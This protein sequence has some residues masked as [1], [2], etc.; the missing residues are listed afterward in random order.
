MASLLIKNIPNELHEHLRERA[1]RH[2]R[3][4]NKE[5]I[6]LLEQVMEGPRPGHLPEPVQLKR[7]IDTKTILRARDEGRR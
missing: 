4:M 6:V 1:A 3:S 5:V 7:P 2:H